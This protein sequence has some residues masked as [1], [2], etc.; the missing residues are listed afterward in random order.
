MFSF[1]GGK[2]GISFLIVASFSS[3]QDMNTAFNSE[4]YSTVHYGEYVIIDTEDKNDPDNGKIFRRGQN[5]GEYFAQIVGPA[6]PAPNLKGDS[7]NNVLNLEGV[8]SS[9]EISIANGSL[10][11]GKRNMGHGI[12]Q[13]NDSIQWNCC[14]VRQD[15]NSD[16]TA[17]I[18]FTVPYP[19]FEFD[20]N[21]ISAYGT[22][23]ITRLDDRSHPFYY[24]Y[25]INIPE[26][27]KGNELKNIRVI[28]PTASNV[29]DYNGKQSDINNQYTILVGDYYDY[30][31]SSN[32]TPRTIYLSNFE[33]P[34]K[35]K[36]NS[37]K[38]LTTVSS[39]GTQSTDFSNQINQIQEM[40]IDNQNRILVKYS[41]PNYQGNISYNGF[42]NWVSIGNLTISDDSNYYELIQ[43]LSS[44]ES[45]GQSNITRIN[46]ISGQIDYTTDTNTIARRVSILENSQRSCVFPMTY[47]YS[48]LT[49]TAQIIYQSGTQGL[50][51]YFSLPF[52]DCDILKKYLSENTDSQNPLTEFIFNWGQD[53]N[54]DSNLYLYANSSSPGYYAI[55]LN[56]LSLVRI[57]GFKSNSLV[58]S[59]RYLI[60][61][62]IGTDLYNTLFQI[63]NSQ[64]GGK[65][66]PFHLHRNAKLNIILDSNS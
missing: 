30:S 44:I 26:S 17:I 14:S 12:D 29:E 19:I 55:P 9:G 50:Y 54:T 37:G 66:F 38:Y 59:F 24:Y 42:D 60:E 61:N 36:L 33:Y 41:D 21:N 25:Q 15:D 46:N 49:G 51:L 56:R 5:G 20:V 48:Y 16:T 28:V 18:G 10:V 57:N 63:G 6:G 52:K 2:P 45:L 27:K 8:H 7:Y 22:I 47:D 39:R 53:Q 65:M 31:E 40:V 4:N 3:I 64:S 34:K 11:P 35:F 32:P 58:I 1:Y 23:N 43:R 13:Y 62:N